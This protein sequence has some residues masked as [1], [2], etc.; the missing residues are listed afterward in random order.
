MRVSPSISP[1][2]PDDEDVYLVLD[3]F[4]GKLGRAW[5]ETADNRTDRETVIADLMDGQFSDPVR[6]VV[7]NT[8]SDHARD[9]SR[10]FAGAILTEHHSKGLEI[11]AFLESFIERHLRLPL[12]HSR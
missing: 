5:R 3:D 2:P 6:V 11:P 8:R 1:A 10:E 7:F 4:G 12:G 9:V